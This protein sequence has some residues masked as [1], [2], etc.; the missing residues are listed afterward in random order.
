[1]PLRAGQKLPTNIEEL[2]GVVKAAVLLLTLDHASA[3]KLLKS[4]R[5]TPSR[6]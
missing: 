2:D 3:G 5:P 4:L 1:M 6:K